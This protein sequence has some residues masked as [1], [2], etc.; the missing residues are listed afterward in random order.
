MSPG[1][2]ADYSAAGSH[3]S[4]NVTGEDV[5]F[6]AT[7]FEQVRTVDALLHSPLLTFMDLF[8]YYL[9]VLCKA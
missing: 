2:T 8:C 3:A 5:A 7:V 6:L 4:G 1:F 9:M